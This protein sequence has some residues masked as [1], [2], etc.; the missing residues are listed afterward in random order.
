MIHI[1]SWILQISVFN[2]EA[3]HICS[4]SIFIPIFWVSIF[5]FAPIE[6]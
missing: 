6:K 5:V 2:C 1:K 3:A 4:I